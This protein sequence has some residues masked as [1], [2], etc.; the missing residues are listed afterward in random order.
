[1]ALQRKA[2]AGPPPYGARK[3]YLPRRA[4]DFG[5][6]GA[7][8]E[9]HMLQYP[10]DM[11]RDKTKATSTTVALQVDEQGKLRYDALARYGHASDAVVL[12]EYKDLV[13]MDITAETAAAWK[14]PSAE[15]VAATTEK[16]RLALEQIVSGKVSSLKSTVVT[17]G[18]KASAP[19][20]V[21][22]T[23][24]SHG[25]RKGKTRV[26]SMVEMPVD[27]LEPPKFGFKRLPPGPPSPPPPVLHSPP[28]KL[29]KKERDEW[30][31]PPCISNWKNAKGYTIPLDKRLAA[32]GRGLQEVVIN[33]RFAQFSEAMQIAE[34]HAR[35][36]VR[37]RAIMQQKIAEKERM[38]REEGLRN[39]AQQAR[40]ER[41]GFGGGPA[42]LGGAGGGRDDHFDNDVDEE[43]ASERGRGRR[44]RSYDSGSEPEG[45]GRRH[46][47]GDQR[48]AGSGGEDEDDEDDEG[49]R[50]R[51][52]LRREKR[53]ELQREYRMSH[54]GAEAKSR[55]AKTMADRDVS[56]KI[57]LGAIKPTVSKDAMFDSRLFN[58]SEGLGSGFGDDEAYDVYDSALFSGTHAGIASV[59]RPAARGDSDMYGGATDANAA[60]EQLSKTDRFQPAAGRG[61]QGADGSSARGDGPVEFE[62]VASSSSTLAPP[63]AAAGPSAAAAAFAGDVFGVNDFMSQARKPRRRDDDEDD[64]R[65]A[66]RSRYD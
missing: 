15:E 13:P 64:R 5:D 27:P 23:P 63:P 60:Y 22:Y 49:A 21:K 42:G 7:F 12:A 10:L 24:T 52:A 3:G 61:F 38:L 48:G 2:A 53:R 56:E 58:Q 30:Q 59:Y 47:R 33:D 1:M 55:H 46:T 20:V 25:G 36:E 9:I 4:E 28:R 32:D 37:Q 62:K 35:E 54:M 6:G 44:D 17:S 8:P 39:L 14:K 26:I 41:S 66:K 65:E 19:T 29:T 45:R 16:T 43:D 31:I 34:R 18:A 50:E 11:G 57:A 51:E 40:E